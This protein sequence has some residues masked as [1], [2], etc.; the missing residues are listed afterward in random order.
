ME[1]A[2]QL[3]PYPALPIIA[4]YPRVRM[5]NV[6]KKKKN[7]CSKLRKK[8]LY[9]HQVDSDAFFLSAELSTEKRIGLQFREA[10]KCRLCYEL[11]CH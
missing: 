11:S 8:K 1:L 7:P 2:M 10:F 3:A 4:H 6:H 5:F 9:Y